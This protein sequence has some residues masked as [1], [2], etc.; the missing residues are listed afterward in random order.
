MTQGN[1]PAMQ[2]LFAVTAAVGQGEIKRI[3]TEEE[4]SLNR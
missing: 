2:A 3:K 4:E 1:V